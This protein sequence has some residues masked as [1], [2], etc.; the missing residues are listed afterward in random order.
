M[1]EYPKEKIL[2]M[3]KLIN[4]FDEDPDIQ[5]AIDDKIENIVNEIGMSEK[6]EREYWKFYDD[7]ILRKKEDKIFSNI[8]YNDGEIVDIKPFLEK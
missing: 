7:L 4:Q 6:E 5:N 1:K 3:V 8:I 2:E